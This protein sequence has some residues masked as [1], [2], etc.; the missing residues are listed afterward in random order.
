MIASARWNVPS[1]HRTPPGSIDENIGLGLSSPR[2][3]AAWMRRV[4]G[5]PVPLT[6]LGRARP[7]RAASSCICTASSR[8]SRLSS[9]SPRQSMSR[10]LT[11]VSDFATPSSSMRNPIA[12]V[13][14]P[15]TIT[16]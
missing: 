5:T 6:M 12:D 7:A 16:S 10:R 2:S 8:A 15:T 13:P 11:Q 1:S 3:I 9:P 14:P 4:R